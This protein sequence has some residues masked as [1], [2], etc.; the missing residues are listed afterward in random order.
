MVKAKCRWQKSGLAFTGEAGGFGVALD[1][2]PSETAAQENANG[3]TPKQLALISIAGCSSM[4]VISLLQKHKQPVEDFWIDCETDTTS[5]HPKVFTGVKL[6]YHLAGAIDRN[7]A[8]E[9][10][11]LS[12]TK[13]CGVSAMFAKAVSIDYVVYLNNEKINEA[14]AKF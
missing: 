14:Q 5:T 7:R 11:Q 8:I 13:Y 1:G 12:M 6:A 2:N 10:V 4:D 3:P 9:A